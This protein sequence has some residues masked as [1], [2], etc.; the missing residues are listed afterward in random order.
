MAVKS[1]KRGESFISAR[2]KGD[3]ESDGKVSS[4]V[5]ILSIW[6]YMI[7]SAILVLPWSFK[8]S[9]MVLAIF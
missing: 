9:G 6:N 7:G 2:D 8:E 5:T 1:T 3:G 4:F